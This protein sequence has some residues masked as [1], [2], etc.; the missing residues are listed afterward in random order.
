MSWIEFDQFN[1]ETWKF[2]KQAF[3]GDDVL[4]ELDSAEIVAII[5]YVD[6]DRD[7]GFLIVRESDLGN[8]EPGWCVGPPDDQSDDPRPVSE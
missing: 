2:L 7:F 4:V 3:R 1:R 8:R 6:F 5:R